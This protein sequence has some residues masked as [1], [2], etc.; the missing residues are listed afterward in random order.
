MCCVL[1]G[2]HPY[3]SARHNF[4]DSGCTRTQT[5]SS[6]SH[7]DALWCLLCSI[8]HMT[9]CSPVNKNNKA[10]K[11]KD[12]SKRS[13]KTRFLSPLFHS[14]YLLSLVPLYLPVC[15]SQHL[16]FLYPFLNLSFFH[17]P[18]FL[19]PFSIS[20]CTPTCSEVDCYTRR[21]APYTLTPCCKSFIESVEV[22]LKEA[23][24]ISEFG[25]A[26]ASG[27]RYSFCCCSAA[28]LC[29]GRIE[30]RRLAGR[31]D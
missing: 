24:I 21:I 1:S 6:Q 30:G 2:W 12:F 25:P 5:A 31:R 16:L 19:M 28:A 17:F 22:F 29:F 14:L 11:R 20:R 3:K 23:C 13:L 7:N 10:K 8:W 18:F 4:P 15:L 9:L 26:W 27:Q